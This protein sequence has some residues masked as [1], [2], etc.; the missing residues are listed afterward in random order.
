[1]STIRRQSI[2]SSGVVY[3]GFGIGAVINFLLLR[4]FNPDQY[5]LVSGMFTAIGTIMFG[6]ANLGSITYIYK[7]YPYY[8]DN[9]VPRKND[10]LT[11][12]LVFSLI[13]FLL[14]SIAGVVFKKQ[15]VHFYQ[16]KSSEL[17]RYYYWL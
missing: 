9:L 10:L 11:R 6:F 15:I 1:M 16:D 14:V 7:F 3:F 13:G 4:E 2:I 5:G 8:Q 12:A 17:V